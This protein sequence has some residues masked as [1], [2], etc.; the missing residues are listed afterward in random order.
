MTENLSW[1]NLEVKAKGGKVVD[2]CLHTKYLLRSIKYLIPFSYSAKPY[3][4]EEAT[5]NF[6]T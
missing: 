6:I 5:L 3:K 1:R 4:S 2:F